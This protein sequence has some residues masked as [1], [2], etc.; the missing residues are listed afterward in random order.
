VHSSVKTF[1]SVCYERVA[2]LWVKTMISGFR[3]SISICCGYFATERIVFFIFFDMN[4][5]GHF[6]I[7]VYVKL[8]I[9]LLLFAS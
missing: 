5:S 1:C 6:H 2:R 4:E 8:L 3:Y 7:F 9:L